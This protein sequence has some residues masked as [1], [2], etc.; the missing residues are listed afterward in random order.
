M[1][2]AAPHARIAP[3]EC[4]SMWRLIAIAAVSIVLPL[5]AAP[6]AIRKIDFKNATYAWDEPNPGVPSKWQWPA[7]LHMV[8]F[9]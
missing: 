5:F 4:D 7:T 6:R 8:A 9:N 3:L 1:T 2:C